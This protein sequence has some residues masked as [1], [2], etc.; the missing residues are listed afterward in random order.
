ML[1][2]FTRLAAPDDQRADD[3]VRP[4]QRNDQDAAI[5]GIEHDLLNVRGRSCAEIGQLDGRAAPRSVANPQIV[6]PDGLVGHRGNELVAHPI[7]RA[8][9]ELLSR[10]AEHID[11]ACIRARQ[12][13]R[14]GYDRLQHHVEIKRR[15]DRLA[16]FPE[17]LQFADRACKLGRARLHFLEETDIL[18]RDHGLVGEGGEQ[19]DLLLVERPHFDATDSAMVPIGF[20]LAQQRHGKDG[21]VALS[22]ASAWLTDIRSGFA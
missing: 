11:R 5:A 3:L 7:G 8:Q 12:L 15:I 14:L 2:E 9:A 4:E 16:D 18:D 17:R 1:V 6:Q 13:N 19:L 10:A 20:A 22:T 21:P